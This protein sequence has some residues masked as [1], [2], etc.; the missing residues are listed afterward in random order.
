MSL[1]GVRRAGFT[2]LKKKTHEVLGALKKA[3]SELFDKHTGISAVGLPADAGST[4]VP[5]SSTD[6]FLCLVSNWK[7]DPDTN[8]MM[9]LETIWTAY[10]WCD[11][12]F[13]IYGNNDMSPFLEG[14]EKR[15]QRKAQPAHELAEQADETM[16][17]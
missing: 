8:L 16:E 11:F 9:W 12:E 7:Q 6:L 5:D 2:R 17:H 3:Q 13:T 1:F 4:W 10:C 14:L 15:P